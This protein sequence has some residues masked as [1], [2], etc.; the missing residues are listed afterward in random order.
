MSY[1]V[2][3]AAIARLDSLRINNKS[4]IDEIKEHFGKSTEDYECD[5]DD[6]EKFDA[7]SKAMQEAYE[8]PDQWLP[9]GSE[10]TCKMNVYEAS[11]IHSLA[12]YTVS[13][14]GDLR[15]VENGDH[16][17]EWFKEK[18]HPFYIPEINLH[19][20]SSVLLPF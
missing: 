6:Q 9:G 1:W 2:H 4:Y 14:H 11:D 8:H 18:F 12:A 13:I 19:R 15:D 16:I 17:I 10:G 7:Y 20:M 3:V 5:W